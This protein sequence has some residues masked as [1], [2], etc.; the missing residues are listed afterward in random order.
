M[1][2]R[3]IL[4]HRAGEALAGAIR[5][6]GGA[7][8]AILELS[9]KSGGKAGSAAVVRAT[10]DC[11]MIPEGEGIRDGLAKAYRE[12]FPDLPCAEFPTAEDLT[13]EYVE[14]RAVLP[15]ED[16]DR[17]EARLKKA[18]KRLPELCEPAFIESFEPK[19]GHGLYAAKLDRESYLLMGF[20]SGSRL[21]A[22]CADPLSHRGRGVDPEYARLPDTE[23]SYLNWGKTQIFKTNRVRKSA[24]APADMLRPLAGER[25]EVAEAFVAFAEAAGLTANVR[26]NPLRASWKCVYAARKPNRVILTLEA[27][28]DSLRIKS[29]L[30]GIGGYLSE[31]A[32]SAEFERQLLTNAWDCGE[33][34]QSCRKGVR[35]DL[36]GPRYKCVGG[37]FTFIDLSREDFLT[38]LEMTKRE[39]SLR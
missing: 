7:G 19:I 12:R 35:F 2:Y 29:N 38:L 18:G 15:V 14:Y 37:A 8:G 1:V 9:A 23:E 16:A 32:P 26:Y 33:C 17:T 30:F 3:M 34:S 6:N 11:A 31:F 27:S 13:C 20:A 39:Y 5:K 4:C 25:A 36:S 24:Y 28:P 21:K 10:V 22:R